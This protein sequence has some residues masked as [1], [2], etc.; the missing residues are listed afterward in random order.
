MRRLTILAALVAAAIAVPLSIGSSHKGGATDVDGPHRRRHGPLRLDHRGRPGVGDDRKARYYINVDNTGD[1][2]AD[3][4][5][6]FRFRTHVRD[7]NTYLYAKPTVDSINDP[8][9]NVR[10]TYSVTRQ[11]YNR[12]GRLVR[13]RRVG[14]GPTAPNNAGKGSRPLESSFGHLPSRRTR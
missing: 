5:Y 13:S 7:R 8:D 11:V 4:R 3:I 10:Q 6:L 2:R 12:R 9:L 1:G 14:G